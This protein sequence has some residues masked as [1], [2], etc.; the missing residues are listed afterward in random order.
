METAKNN[1]MA[2]RIAKPSRRVWHFAKENGL[3]PDY[4]PGPHE[5][6]KMI[7]F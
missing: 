5:T 2:L 1:E 7:E 4:T 6:S 3:G